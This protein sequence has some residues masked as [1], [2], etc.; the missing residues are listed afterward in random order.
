[1][2]ARE[3]GCSSR[4]VGRRLRRNSVHWGLNRGK[5]SSSMLIRNPG[6]LSPTGATGKRDWID[7]PV[8]VAGRCPN[9][10]VI[11][12]SLDVPGKRRPCPVR[13]RRAVGLGASSVELFHVDPT[14]QS[15]ILGFASVTP[16]SLA[17]DAGIEVADD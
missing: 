17:R 9:E 3:D 16:P 2:P 13:S 10:D 5:P 11:D 8:R 6:L 12:V 4:I 15:V 7:D 1:M 14:Q